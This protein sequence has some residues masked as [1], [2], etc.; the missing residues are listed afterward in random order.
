MSP[1]NILF[2]HEDVS[3]I[4]HLR[5]SYHW[6]AGELGFR[7]F[8]AGWK[9]IEVS[10]GGTSIRDGYE[11]VSSSVKRNF[12][13]IELI[14]P[15]II[16][17][18][19]LIWGQSEKLFE[20]LAEA[21]PKS[22]ISYRPH[23][24]P[25]GDKWVVELC[26][27]SAEK[28]GTH[29]ARPTTY[30]AEK[31]EMIERLHQIGHTKPLIFKP[32]SGSECKGIWLSEPETFDQVTKD[33]LSS[34]WTRYIVQ[35]LIPDSVLYCGK[36]L[37]LRVYVLVE[38]FQPLRFRLYREGVARIAA[39]QFCRVRLAQPLCALTGSSYRKRLGLTVE[40]LPITD[41]LAYL[42]RIGYRVGGF[43]ED[44]EA[45]VASVLAALGE[46]EPLAQE[47]NSSRR[48]YLA[49]LDFLMVPK[50]DSFSFLFLETNYVPQL[51]DWGASV[52]SR[53]EKVHRQWLRELGDIHNRP[54]A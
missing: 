16:V 32:A 9:G 26:M 23:W 36:K 22:L 18:R 34:N 3:R 19:K 35:D 41:V 2:V 44:L 14:Q 17:H 25:I 46:Y 42:E 12:S 5:S 27:R 4:D 47:G 1:L 15:D 50:G 48:F 7:A 20:K 29:V 13:S 28:R 11:A 30:L 37:D 33:V 40:N 45:L 6:L 10:A 21:Y 49:G 51:T 39:Q 43:W 24:K 53:L 52:D 38:S 31:S 8:I 54:A